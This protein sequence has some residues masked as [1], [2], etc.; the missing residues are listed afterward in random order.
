MGYKEFF[1]IYYNANKASATW[2][3]PRFF[4]AKVEDSERK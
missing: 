1:K 3:L 4:S 2:P